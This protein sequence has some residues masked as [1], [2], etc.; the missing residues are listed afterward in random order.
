METNRDIKDLLQIA[1]DNFDKMF[2]NLGLCG[3]FA[4][5]SDNEIITIVEY[6]DLIGFIYTNKPNTLNVRNNIDWFWTPFL[7]RPR[8]E[9][10][11]RMI[12]KLNK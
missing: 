8:K 3:Y 12:K 11:K 4:K 2:D 10:L 1:L 7:K 9:Y 6:S 5:L